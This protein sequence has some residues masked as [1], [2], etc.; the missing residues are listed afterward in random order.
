M[1]NEQNASGAQVPC[2]SLL[3]DL[4]SALGKLFDQA[5]IVPTTG[6]QIVGCEVWAT[7]Y[8]GFEF[9]EMRQALDA[10][11]E[12]LTANADA[13]GSAV[14]DTVRRDVGNSVGGDK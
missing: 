10:L 13:D 14:A 1:A 6:G 3:A 11:E 7:Q 4:K 5:R 2:I 12:F 8:T 9:G